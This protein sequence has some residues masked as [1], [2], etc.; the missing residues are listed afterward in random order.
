MISNTKILVVDDEPD[1]LFAT[2]RIL[3]QAGYVVLEADTGE[4]AI[5]S[6]RERQ[7]D[8]VLHPL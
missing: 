1:V 8:I 6:A 4:A 7:P 2:S 5:H 3:K